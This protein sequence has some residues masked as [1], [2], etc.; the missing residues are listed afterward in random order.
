MRSGVAGATVSSASRSSSPATESWYPT[1][2]IQPSAPASAFA[3]RGDQ[4]GAIADLRRAD[5]NRG[6]RGGRGV[7]VHMVIVK[8]R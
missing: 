2:R 1:A 6:R 4:C 3:Q 5:P 7:Q 8:A